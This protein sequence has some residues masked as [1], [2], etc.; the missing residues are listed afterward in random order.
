MEK[1][2]IIMILFIHGFIVEH[3]LIYVVCKYF[4]DQNH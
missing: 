2:Q 3:T 1:E 4:H